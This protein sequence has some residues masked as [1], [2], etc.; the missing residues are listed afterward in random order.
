MTSL[1]AVD[2]TGQQADLPAMTSSPDLP[3][4]VPAYDQ[5]MTIDSA[6]LTD[7]QRTE[8]DNADRTPID[9]TF[10][11]LPASD[12]DGNV[13]VGF[14]YPGSKA[15]MAPLICELLGLDAPKGKGPGAFVEVFGGSAAVLLHSRPRS[16]EVYNDRNDLVYLFFKV[17]RD[18]PRELFHALYW[19]PYSK[20]EFDNADYNEPGLTDLERV[21]RWVVRTNQTMPGAASDHR[22]KF[23]KTVKDAGQSNA[24]KWL[25]YKRR[26]RA[27]GERFQKVQITNE[28]ALDLIAQVV[29]NN[30]PS[31]AMYLDPPYLTE[32]R[33]LTYAYD[34]A[35]EDHAKM[36]ALIVGYAGPCVVSGYDHPIYRQLDDAS[37][38]ERVEVATR[39]AQQAKRTEVLWTNRPPRA[40][41]NMF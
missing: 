1:P 16:V 9:D 23:V 26:L 39:N 8:A 3:V 27:I 6:V 29:K 21:R 31:T 13:D 7:Q 17:C 34:M 24:T 40:Q 28:D 4:T 20:T 15:S 14:Q 11:D 10:D 32:T 41:Q 22:G 33:D 19:T 35:D 12:G 18:Q 30:D 38:W 5:G 36:I 25:R 37:G 2:A